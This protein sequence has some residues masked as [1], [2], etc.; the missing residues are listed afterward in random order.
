[1][2]VHDDDLGPLGEWTQHA[3]GRQVRAVHR[4]HER[5]AEQAD[6]RHGRAVRQGGQGVFGI[7]R[8]FRVEIVDLVS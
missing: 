1:M 3:V 2:G 8:N 4:P 5:P 7:A 6:D